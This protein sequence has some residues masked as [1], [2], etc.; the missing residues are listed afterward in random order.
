MNFLTLFLYDRDCLEY[1]IIFIKNTRE[2]LLFNLH[3]RLN[4]YHC[5]RLPLANFPLITTHEYYGIWVRYRLWRYG[6]SDSMTAWWH[7]VFIAL[8]GCIVLHGIA[9]RA[10]HYGRMALWRHGS[11]RYMTLPHYGFMAFYGIKAT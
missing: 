11:Q 4:S 8:W 9:W 10:W 2:V 5:K 6:A 7:G 1:L 3:Q